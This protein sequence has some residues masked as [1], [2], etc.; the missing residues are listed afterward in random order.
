M[1]IHHPTSFDIVIVI[2]IG[3]AF[4]KNRKLDLVLIIDFVIMVSTRK[5]TKKVS[6]ISTRKV[7]AVDCFMKDLP[8]YLW[9][10]NCSQSRNRTPREIVKPCCQP[11]IYKENSFRFQ[12]KN[13]YLIQEYIT[14]ELDLP[15]KK[16]KQTQQSYIRIDNVLLSPVQAVEDMNLSNEDC[17]SVSSVPSRSSNTLGDLDSI[18]IASATSVANEFL[19]P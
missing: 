17:V 12:K 7:G 13:Y 2:I 10:L 19:K 16:K 8:S 18:S 11:W 15:V 9:C 1:F 3:F 4:I 5:S 14:V 6:T